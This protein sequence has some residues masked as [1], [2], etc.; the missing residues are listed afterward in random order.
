MQDM[1][2]LKI[3]KQLG[4]LYYTNKKGTGTK[5]RRKYIYNNSDQTFQNP[6][7]TNMLDGREEEKKITNMRRSKILVLLG[8]DA[9]TGLKIS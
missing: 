9:N 1:C 7:N 4:K 6:D 3:I 5:K 2:E 8:K